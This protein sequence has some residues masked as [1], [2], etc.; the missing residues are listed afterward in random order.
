M[1]QFNDDAEQ[2]DETSLDELRLASTSMVL[3][4]YGVF[5]SK[6][7]A[8]TCADEIPCESNLTSNFKDELIRSAGTI[9]PERSFRNDIPLDSEMQSVEVIA[10]EHEGKYDLEIEL[11]FFA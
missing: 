2:C 7:K 11:S 6:E 1:L 9:P 10:Q 3:T 5:I 4:K 8:T